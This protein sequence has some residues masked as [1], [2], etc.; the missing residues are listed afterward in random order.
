MGEQQ[1]D[2]LRMFLLD[3]VHELGGVHILQEAEARGADGALHLFQDFLGAARAHGRFQGLARVFDAALEDVFLGHGHLM[4]FF[5][6]ALAGLG[7]DTVQAGDFGGE[8]FHILLVEALEDLRAR[9][10]SQGNQHDRG[11]DGTADAGGRAV[12][13]RL[14]AFRIGLGSACHIG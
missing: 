10:R 3:E 1:G 4:E 6:H 2:G 5:Q 7:R 9:F 12:R 11:F 14:F 13:R 8:D